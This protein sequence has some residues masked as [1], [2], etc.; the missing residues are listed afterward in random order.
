MHLLNYSFTWISSRIKAQVNIFL[1]VKIAL[2]FFKAKTV[3][4]TYK[5]G[6]MFTL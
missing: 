5:K 1:K 3:G 4:K 2:F 6:D